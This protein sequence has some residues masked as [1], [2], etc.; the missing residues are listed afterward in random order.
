[1]ILTIV[2]QTAFHPANVAHLHPLVTIIEHLS[3]VAG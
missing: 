2:K 1:M 3:S